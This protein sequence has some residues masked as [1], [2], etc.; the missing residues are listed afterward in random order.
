MSL[1][2]QLES[3]RRTIP[4]DAMFVWMYRKGIRGEASLR[5]YVVRKIRN[6]VF[7][8][9]ALIVV[10]AL[11]IPSCA[12]A[13]E[14]DQAQTLTVTELLENPHSNG[15]TGHF[16]RV[17]GAE[18]SVAYCAQGWLITPTQGQTLT[19]YGSLE[20]PELDYV[21]YHG[22]DG[23][24]VTSVFGLDE[25]ESE[26]ATTVAVWLA[27]ADQRGDILDFHPASGEPFHGN[28]M[29]YERWQ[30]LEEGP[31]KDA[32]MQ[33]YED[34][35]EYRDAGGGGIEAG[36]A[37]YWTNQTVYEG[38]GTYSYQGVVTAD[39]RVEVTFEKASA[40]P[41]ITDGNEHY[42]LAGASYDLFRTD[43]GELVSTITTDE[44]GRATA[45][46]I[47]QLTYH[48]VEAS[49]P[50][51][52]ALNTDPIEFSAGFEPTR[53]TLVDDPQTFTFIIAKADA[54]T[55]G[56]A[57]P[58]A[59]LAGAEYELSSASTP[60]FS[61]TGTTDENGV[62]E[63]SGVPLGTV[64]IVERKA[65][66]GYMLDTT[67]HEYTVTAE[68]IAS[69][70]TAT[71]KPELD[72]LE[73]PIAFDIDI[74][75]TLSETGDD[76]HAEQ[77]L[78]GIV[79]QIIS[80]DS[81][82]VVGTI[83]TDE[84]GHASTTGTWMGN[85][86]RPEAAHGSIPYS[87]HGY[88]V[89][90]DPATMPAGCK[91]AEDW[92]IAPEDMVDGTTLRYQVTNTLVTAQL[93][94]VKLDADTDAPVRQEGFTFSILTADGQPLPADA[95]YPEGSYPETFTTDETG[96]V[97][98]PARLRTGDYLL[99]ETAA[100]APY[101]VAADDVPFSV[102]EDAQEPVLTVCV[103]DSAAR[104]R[105]TLVKTCAE[106]GCSLEGAEFDVIAQEDIVA[107]D[108]TMRTLAGDVVDHVTTD[109]EGRAQTDELP[110]G[111]GEAT[112]AFVETKTPAGHALDATPHVF[113]LSYQDQNTAVMSTEIEVTNEPTSIELTKTRADD[114]ATPVV[115]AE[116]ALYEGDVDT[117]AVEGADSHTDK[118]EG[119]EPNQDADDAESTPEEDGT[120]DTADNEGESSETEPAAQVVDAGEEI[121]PKEDEEEPNEE[122]ESDSTPADDGGD[123]PDA[124]TYT[125]DDQGHL[126]IHHLAP[127][128]YTLRET[129]APDGY[130]V[131][132]TSVTFT[133]DEQGLIDG[134]AQASFSLTNDVTKIDVYKRN[135]DTEEAVVGAQLAVTDEAGNT[136]DV[137][138]S[139]EGPHRLTGIAP[140]TYTLTETVAPRDHEA[141]APLIFT[142][143]N[144]ADVQT[145]VMYD[146]PLSIDG[147]IDKRQEAAHPIAPDAQAAD[148]GASPVSDDGT[149]AYSIDVR[150]TSSTWVDEF[151][152]TD[153][154]ECVEAGMAELESVV[155][156]VATGDYDGKL[157][158][159]YKLSANGAGP[160]EV[161]AN[162][163]LDD[164]HANP[165][166]ADPSTA[167]TLGDDGRAL[168][169]NGWHLWTD[170]ISATRAT[171]L[172][173]SELGLPKEARIVAI[174]FEFGCV[175]SA[176]TTYADG[177]DRDGMKD[178]T[179]SVE[180]A[181]AHSGEEAPIIVRM[182][183][184]HAYRADCELANTARLDIVRNGGGD[185]LQAQDVDR[186][187]QRAQPI[188]RPLDQTGVVLGGS[189][190]V[191]ATACSLGAYAALHVDGSGWRR[192]DDRRPMR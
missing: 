149:F 139:D 33:L 142:V 75:K 7:T 176:F 65:P 111:S 16:L 162:A 39:K 34:A 29:F 147:E 129:S 60:G 188:I 141:S 178:E 47:P 140:G 138:I 131:G 86:T 133:V 109:A 48:A 161:G 95:W 168:D 67:V 107:P 58:G 179:D 53:V 42:V 70:G 91:P 72:F 189:A 27:I 83:T 73:V 102:T 45:R 18:S 89:H 40:D 97:S 57:Q 87:E 154:L 52:Y 38:D 49:A 50:A 120:D 137:W 66:A 115:G 93:Q 54:A 99:R 124:P 113:T 4:Q 153:E 23:N 43:T 119:G 96:T 181:Q 21:M 25:Q 144:T 13:Q 28:K 152:V 31:V 84:S 22:Y 19:R 71:I 183:V 30:R 128:T 55:N 61:L 158:V 160:V 172:R 106:G 5:R 165:W 20:I 10:A 100:P 78:G 159:W 98:L 175:D 69:D 143:E 132:D 92:T 2:K 15:G 163:T 90:E 79:F 177:W 157:N 81:G 136:I 112:Y 14:V 116:F 171:E 41:A 35:L 62:I 51:G 110:L 59:T 145:V 56:T 114:E 156:P 108:G 185:G 104:G 117:D 174:R 94:I 44:N 9:L 180:R 77:P 24:Y 122:D 130:V 151:T 173:V 192:L 121:D 68:D 127:G 6:V 166:L 148:I 12:Q 85:G 134:N 150:N 76:T 164:A 146:A 80:N 169:Y 3:I 64:R 37:S 88:T 103:R 36:C 155:T 170:G 182:R 125:T 135:A 11:F 26:A 118:E 123:T 17:Q 186:V 1:S 187:V 167:N 190:L 46:L 184:N 82:E 191:V 74:D 105:A 32:A 63:F 101:T 8:L 126:S